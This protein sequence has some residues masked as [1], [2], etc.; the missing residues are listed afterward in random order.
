[1]NSQTIGAK[2]DEMLD[3]ILLQNVAPSVL[4]TLAEEQKKP[5]FD[6]LNAWW[7]ELTATQN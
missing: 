4:R 3:S 6:R 5:D 2:L 1:M 7:A